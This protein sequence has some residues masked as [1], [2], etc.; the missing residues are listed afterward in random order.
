MTVLLEKHE[1]PI[2]YSITMSIIKFSP[3]HLEWLN[4]S[5]EERTPEEILTWCSMSLPNLLQS[6]AFGPSGM[7]M[8]H[9]LWK[10]KINIPTLFIDTLHNFPETLKHA[11]DSKEKYNIDLQVY[12]CKTAESQETFEKEHGKELWKTESEQYDF[13]VKVEPQR[14]ALRELD[15]FAWLNGRRRSQGDDRSDLKI[16]E[17][18]VDGRLKINPLVNWSYEQVWDYIKENDVLYN[19]L[20]DKGYKSIGDKMTSFPVG[21][22]DDERAG[23]W[24]G[25][26][27]TEC[28][29]H[30][31]VPTSSS[32]L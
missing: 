26:S 7:V 14:R 13:L 5:L 32:K 21:K 15:I 27:K 22:D 19:P 4:E 20:H 24:Q 9:M 28:G 1:K 10:L 16:I 17:Y 3:E 12:R 25:S 18:S 6:T 30:I 8:V 11:Q 23:R 31:Q 29:I 2:P